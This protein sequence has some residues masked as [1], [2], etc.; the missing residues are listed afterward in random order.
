MTETQ[1]SGNVEGKVK[2]LF[3]KFMAWLLGSPVV[4]SIVIILALTVVVSGAIAFFILIGVF[5]FTSS[6]TKEIWLEVQFQLLNAIFT[7][8]CLV[9]QPFRL[10][11]MYYSIAIIS[12]QR[13]ISSSLSADGKSI[14]STSAASPN[15][16][17]DNSKCKNLEKQEKLFSRLFSLFSEL[18][19]KF[20]WFIP[21]QL[22]NHP[23]SATDLPVK[24][25]EIGQV[26]ARE[27]FISDMTPFLLC[28]ISFTIST[29]AQ[30]VLTITMWFFHP[31]SSRPQIPIMIAL[32][33]SFLFSL[34]G[35]IFMTLEKIKRKKQLK[36][37]STIA[38]A[39]TQITA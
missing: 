14:S 37:T 32:P 10:S 13:S 22:E 19:Q 31:P 5:T 25:G 38:A 39:P 2:K 24:L 15:G 6:Q 3:R 30:I 12:T 7:L 18:H 27:L 35:M 20:P 36:L 1:P 11:G 17:I 4:N 8:A 29:L 9:D 34:F 33:V 26:E 16:S 28:M 21:K 23:H